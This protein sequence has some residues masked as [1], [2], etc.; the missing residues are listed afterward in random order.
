DQAQGALRDA[1]ATRAADG[2]LVES[3]REELVRCRTEHAETQAQLVAVLRSA[4]WRVTKP[5]RQALRSFRRS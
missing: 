2:A 3:L 1:A 5:I 4:S